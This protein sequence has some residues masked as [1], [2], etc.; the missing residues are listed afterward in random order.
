M[1]GFK[2]FVGKHS[3]HSF[4]LFIYCPFASASARAHFYLGTKSQRHYSF[5]ITQIKITYVENGFWT[6]IEVSVPQSHHP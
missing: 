4:F 3:C 6:R 2:G 5:R 1:C